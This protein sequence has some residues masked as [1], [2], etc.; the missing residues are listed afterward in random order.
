MRFDPCRAAEKPSFRKA[1]LESRCLVPADGASTDESAPEGEGL[2]D[3]H[4][5]EGLAK[6]LF[7]PL[8]T[9]GVF[10]L[11]LALLGRYSQLRRLK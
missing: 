2:S 11:L 9:P 10:P 4:L 8:Y 3:V 1:F 5:V 7:E 6:L